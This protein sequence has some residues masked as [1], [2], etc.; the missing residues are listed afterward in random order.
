MSH[1]EKA[2]RHEQ[3]VAHCRAWADIEAAH[4]A[5]QGPLVEA[6]ERALEE[7]ARARAERAR[8]AKSMSPGVDV[9]KRP[10]RPGGLPP[11]G[12]RQCPQPALALGRCRS[13]FDGQGGGEEFEDQIRTIASINGELANR[14]PR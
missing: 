6:A 10:T 2:A 5:R 3:A 7:V 13:M 4:E 8:L 1:I 12:R 9:G 11:S 14:A